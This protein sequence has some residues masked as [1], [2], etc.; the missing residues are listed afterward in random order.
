MNVPK[1]E[2]T[3][4][5]SSSAL[6]TIDR[7]PSAHALCVHGRYF[8]I[9]CGEGTQIRLRQEGISPIRIHHIFLSHL[10]GDHMLGIFGL[11]S[12]MSMHKR[13]KRLHIYGPSGIRRL[14]ETHLELM[15]EELTFQ[16]EFHEMQEGFEGVLIEDKS[17]RVTAFPLNHRIV[18]FGYRFQEKIP[19]LNIRKEMIEQYQLDYHQI[20]ELKLGR[21]INVNG[22]FDSNGAPY[23]LS[24]QEACYLPFAPRS[25]AYCSDTQYSP[26]IVPHIQGVDLL[27]HEATFDASM[28]E[29][30]AQTAHS[31]SFD[32]ARIASLAG[33]G[34]LLIGHYS[35]RYKNN[36]KLE[37]EARSL[38]PETT[39]VN[40]GDRFSIPG[41]ES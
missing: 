28:D 36:R 1:F 38:F 3:V 11:L 8:L 27:Y 21:S 40:D 25:Y 15:Q 16:L 37:E 35:S 14:L 23:V 7:F 9:D 12:S 29:Y 31:T 19:V 17:L 30:A 22:I 41:H 24:P 33:V 5:G 26:E 10:H 13:Q 20:V 2:L 32:A 39:A 34:R 4:L 6:P 18:C